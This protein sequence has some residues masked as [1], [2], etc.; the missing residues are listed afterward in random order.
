[1][2][3]KDVKQ[4]L[5]ICYQHLAVLRK[6][7]RENVDRRMSL[8]RKFLMIVKLLFIKYMSTS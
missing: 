1:M 8:D 7:I 6:E 5:A 4:E 3:E 2:M